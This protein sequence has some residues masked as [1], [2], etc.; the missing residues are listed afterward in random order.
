MALFTPLDYKAPALFEITKGDSAAV[1]ANNLAAKGFAPFPL[2]ASLAMRFYGFDKHLKAGEYSFDEKMNFKQILEK[3]TSGKVVMHRLTLP[4]GLTTA[5]M[6]V[7]L[8]QNAF[9]SGSLSEKVAEGEILPETY[10]FAKGESKNNILRKA[11]ADMQKILEEVWQN[12][13]DNLPL[14]NKFELLVLA[15][16]VEKETG[17]ECVFIDLPTKL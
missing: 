15:S 7:L 12:R 9:L 8:N 10:T 14:K 13:A 2:F 3:L 6:L 5:Q 16:I 17:I 4:E 1:T 11:T